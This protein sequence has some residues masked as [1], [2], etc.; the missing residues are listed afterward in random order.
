[1]AGETMQRELKMKQLRQILILVYR[2]LTI[3]LH[4]FFNECEKVIKNVIKNEITI[5]VTWAKLKLKHVK[6]LNKK[7]H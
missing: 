5:I 1:M 4:I 2:V 3:S 7:C 6:W